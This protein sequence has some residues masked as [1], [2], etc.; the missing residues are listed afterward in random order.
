MR[1][2]D[3]PRNV[4]PSDGSEPLPPLLR[5]RAFRTIWA[6]VEMSFLGMFISVVTGAWL[7]TATGASATMVALVQSAYALPMVLF[8]VAAGTL[9]DI[10]DRRRTMLCSLGLAFV[11]SVGMAVAGGAGSLSPWAILGFIFAIGT[12]VAF[13]N[14]AWQ[15]SLGDIVPRAQLVEAVSLHGVGANAMRTIGPSLG[16]LLVALWGATTALGFAAMTYLPALL[17]LYRRPRPPAGEGEREAFLPAFWQSFRYLSV[18]PRLELLLLRAF[19]YCLA[20]I[21]IM[22]LLPLIA[23]EQLGGDVRIYGFLYGGYGCGA[24]LGGLLLRCLRR[25]L[26]IETILSLSVYATAISILALV[27]SDTLLLSLPAMVLAGAAWLLSLSLQNSVLQLLAPRWIAGRLVAAYMTCSNLGMATGGLIWGLL[28]DHYDAVTALTVAGSLLV[29]PA[30]LTW[31]YPLPESPAVNPEPQPCHRLPGEPHVMQGGPLYIQIE[32]DILPGRLDEF[33]RLMPQRRRHITQLGG[34]GWTLLRDARNAGRWSESFYVA[35]WLTYRRLMERR[36]EETAALRAMAAACQ[37]NGKEPPV[38]LMLFT[39]T[40]VSEYGNF[41][42]TLGQV[43][44]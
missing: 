14:P 5:N 23:R 30:L 18:A 31:L 42:N 34:G 20:A 21:S 12:G 40:G 13:F 27:F 44:K 16:G 8:A 1:R 4:R 38:R 24:I 17:Q 43:D 29:V 39:Q 10:T 19:V 7:M 3:D 28:A 6:A 2:N 26:R 32:H 25:R 9:A 33:R 37:R 41:L 22:A 15:S 35:N 11:A 36:S